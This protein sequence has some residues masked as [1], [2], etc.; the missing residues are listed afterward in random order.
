MLYCYIILSVYQHHPGRA[1]DAGIVAQAGQLDGC[2]PA[3]AEG[4]FLII[5]L[6]YLDEGLAG[7]GYAAADDDGFGVYDGGEDRQGAAKDV[8]KPFYDID[9]GFI[10]F[11]IGIEYLLGS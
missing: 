2:L 3:G 4:V 10:P 6:Q 11:L 9:S 8:A 5:L 1:I 7:A